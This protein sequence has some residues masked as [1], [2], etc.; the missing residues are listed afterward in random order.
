MAS[1][2]GD[3]TWLFSYYPTV[4]WTVP[5]GDYNPQPLGEQ[6]ISGFHTFHWD[7]FQLADLLFA[8]SNGTRM[9]PLGFFFLFFFSFL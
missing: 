4:R 3:A 1:R 6:T 7:S 2:L 9:I 8:V 5:G